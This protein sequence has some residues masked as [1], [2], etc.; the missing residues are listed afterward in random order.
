MDRVG[1]LRDRIALVTGGARGIGAAIAR[2][3]AD[4]GA[5]VVIADIDE[6]E[7]N[8]FAAS[9]EG[10]TVRA[11][12]IV[13]AESVAKLA[14]FIAD[15]F[16]KLDILVN[17]AA[18]LD[19]TPYDSLTMER[20]R[21]V[22]DVNLNGALQVV[23]ACVPLM[24][25]TGRG[26]RILNIAS[27]MG[28]RGSR[29]SLA[30]STAKGGVVNM[31]RCLACDLAPDGITV[32][33]ICPGFIDTRMALLPDG[34]GHEHETDWF[35]DIYVK[36]RRIPLARAGLPEDVAGPAYFLCSDDSAYV[37]GQVLLV[38]GGVSATF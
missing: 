7:A 12:D 25:K 3:F 32:N 15:R 1:H 9:F 28:V 22:L 19:A 34:S 24:R 10:G 36:Y 23:F 5:S 31:T 11:V 35:Q 30:Y 2:R 14:S 21:K 20:Y 33:A 4:E 27:I 6:A 29:D 13:D 8:A 37:T 26:G 17:N 16:G 38:D 18:I